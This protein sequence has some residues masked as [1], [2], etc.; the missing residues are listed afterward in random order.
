M[1]R[2]VLSPTLFLL[3]AAHD[4]LE[5]V[6]ALLESLGAVDAM[7]GGGSPRYVTTPLQFAAKSGYLEVSQAASVAGKPCSC[8]CY[9]Y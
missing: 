8:G 4:H 1:L 3:A 6:R 9:E 2:R 7:I 5:A